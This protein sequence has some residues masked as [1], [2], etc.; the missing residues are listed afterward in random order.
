MKEQARITEDKQEKKMTGGNRNDSRKK[1]KLLKTILTDK[2]RSKII[3][4]ETTLEK[5]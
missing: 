2:N 1:T 3:K 4:Q 5:F